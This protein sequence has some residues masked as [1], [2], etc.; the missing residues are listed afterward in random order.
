MITNN[1]D[2]IVNTIEEIF[3]ILLKKHNDLQITKL[4]QFDQINLSR[5]L[6]SFSLRKVINALYEKLPPELQNLE[7]CGACDQ[8]ITND[9]ILIWSE[10]YMKFKEIYKTP[11][12][13]KRNN[14]GDMIV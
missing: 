5:G 9:E 8:W 2:Y 4:I 12:H 3:L 14:I 13:K 11:S 1:L 6:T 10:Q 7:I